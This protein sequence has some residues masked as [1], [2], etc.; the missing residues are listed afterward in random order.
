MLGGLCFTNISLLLFQWGIRVCVFVGI[1]CVF[2]DVSVM[3]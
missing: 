3:S 1:F 2:Q